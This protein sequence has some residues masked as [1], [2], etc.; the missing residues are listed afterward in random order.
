VE[1]FVQIVGKSSP[2]DVLSI[3]LEGNEFH[4][5]L[6]C[7][8]VAT[9][10]SPRVKAIWTLGSEPF[11]TL[12]YSEEGSKKADSF[13]AIWQEEGTEVICVI[14]Y[15]PLGQWTG[16]EIVKK[17]GKYAILT[18]SASNFIEEHPVPQSI[19]KTV[20]KWGIPENSH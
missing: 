5:S 6:V 8:R 9:A 10:E 11:T 20:E 2:T 1:S 19:A 12:G 18:L 13:F 16:L 3:G 17:K 4:I 15:K 14:F 7:E